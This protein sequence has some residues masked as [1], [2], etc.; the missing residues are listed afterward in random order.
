MWWMNQVSQSNSVDIDWTTNEST[1]DFQCKHNNWL[2]LHSLSMCHSESMD[3]ISLLNRLF[4]LW[5]LSLIGSHNPLHFLL[6][7]WMQRWIG[8]P[9]WS[10]DSQIVQQWLSWW[11]WLKCISKSILFLC[12]RIQSQLMLMLIH[13]L[14]LLLSIGQPLQSL[15]FLLWLN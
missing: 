9:P 12:L 7:L 11:E 10:N 15:H 4:P 8:R 3:C 2:I 1:L 13:P 6:P 5:L 14:C